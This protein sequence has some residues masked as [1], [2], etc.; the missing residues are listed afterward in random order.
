MPF[1]WKRR[2]K[3]WYGRYRKRWRF[4]KYKTRRRR[5]RFTRRRN[6]KPTRRRRRRR[7]KV[8][9]KKAKIPVVQWQPDSIRKC[10]IKGVGLLVLG[11]EGTQ[12]N[13][14]TTDRFRYVPPKVPGGGGFGVEDYTLKYLY[15][16]YRLKNN[17]WTH[18]N[19]G[20][21]L[22]RYLYCTLTFYRHEHVDFIICYD[23]QPPH[24][25]NKWTF[26]SCHPQQMLL[27]KNKKLI[28]SHAS[29]T[30]GKYKVRVKIK[31]PKQM[32]TKWFFT[33]AFCEYSL[34][35]LKGTAANMR[36]AYQAG[37]SPNRLVNLS[38]L[39]LLFYQDS[40]WGQTREQGTPY[41]P[42]HG[43]PRS[44]QFQIGTGNPF[45]Y[46]DA[47]Q[48]YAN[49][50]SWDKGW[51]ASKILKVTNIISGTVKPAVRP[52]TH[53]RYNPAQ[54]TGEGNLIYIVSIL[55]EG[56]DVPRVDK[57]LVLEGVPLWLGL[58]G[59]VSYLK[60]IK[61]LDFLLQC[62]VVLKSTAL[63]CAPEIG[64]CDKYVPIDQDY[65]DGK[66][67]YDIPVSTKDKSYWYPNIYWQLKTI[68]AIV[69]SGPYIP[70]YSEETYSNWELK[71]KYDFHF[72]WGG[73]HLPEQ[74]VKNPQQLNEYNVP[75]TL[76][77][78]IQITNP[79]KQATETIIHP[80]DQR[81]GFIKE[82][83]LK[84]MYEHLETDTEFET[85]TEKAKKAKL[86][87]AALRNPQKETEEIQSCLLSLCEE[88]TCQKEKTFEQ[89]IQQQREQQ[90]QLKYTIL[91]LIFDLKEKQR[92]LQLQTGMFE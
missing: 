2:R 61:P 33:K 4:Q 11:E 37:K 1:W 76:Q 26:P 17:I 59:L 8:R 31:P 53:A 47:F 25:I 45:P 43:I 74:D 22:C 67:P 75:D 48:S 80:W 16:E 83:A 27:E 7:Y 30:N 51:F 10:K 92:M 73:P 42:Y 88:S 46:T 56:W 85:S 15:E 41:V 72:K 90:Q 20:K 19:I 14:F 65:I 55:H 21:D 40:S 9:R 28:L 35:L 34:F 6:R 49:S 36:Y 66:K 63:Y 87:G 39:N 62:V 58:F 5:R 32:L 18:T 78:R 57:N 54:D 70:K 44:I 3:P 82:S 71:Y 81:R 52:M 60:T 13:C 12:M 84:R 91:K 50:I 69:E 86:S 89:L 77:H 24:E 68:N 29:Q 79:Q 64:G 23:R 38:S